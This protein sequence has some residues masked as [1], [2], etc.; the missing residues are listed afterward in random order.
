MSNRTNGGDFEILENSLSS[1]ISEHLEER[2]YMTNEVN[3]LSV[4]LG[5]DPHEQSSFLDEF[6]NHGEDPQTIV[7]SPLEKEENVMT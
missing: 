3:Q 7:H 2:S 5:E 6:S 1:W 4:S